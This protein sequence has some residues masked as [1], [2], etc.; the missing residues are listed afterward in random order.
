LVSILI[1][2]Q[3]AAVIGLFRNANFFE[4]DTDMPNES[5]DLLATLW[6]YQKKDFGDDKSKR[7]FLAI[8]P[9]TPDFA[10]FCLGFQA[11]II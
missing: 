6:K 1:I 5:W 4:L 10:D 11:C 2:E 3:A 8:G 9:Q 7:W